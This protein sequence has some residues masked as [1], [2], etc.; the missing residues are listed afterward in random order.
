MLRYLRG[1]FVIIDKWHLASLNSSPALNP[2][3]SL[4]TGVVFRTEKII[5]E[6]FE[7]IFLG[8]WGRAFFRYRGF[9]CD[10]LLF[11]VRPIVHLFLWV[12]KPVQASAAHRT[13]R[14]LQRCMEATVAGF[15]SRPPL[16][17]IPLRPGLLDVPGSHHTC[18][19]SFIADGL[20][21]KISDSFLPI[22]LISFT[23]QTLARH[24][25]FL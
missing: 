12:M 10:A 5:A 11:A 17:F 16:H 14:R 1:Y 18:Q 7:A 15:A 13:S 21:N 2:L 9:C 8:I 23:G 20:T 24:A 25:V 22:P 19:S 3:C 4:L 6:I